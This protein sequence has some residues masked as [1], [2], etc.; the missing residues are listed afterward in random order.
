MVLAYP[1]KIMF[2]TFVPAI[3]CL[4]GGSESANA[5]SISLPQPQDQALRSPNH[6]YR[7]VI[8]FDFAWRHYNTPVEAEAAEYEASCGPAF[9]PFE[10]KTC[11]TDRPVGVF[12]SSGVCETLCCL[13]S[14]CRGWVFE[15]AT[16][17][18]RLDT[19]RVFSC[20]TVTKA[21]TV[22][23]TRSIPAPNPPLST[24][25]FQRMSQDFDDS[26]WQ[27]VDAPHDSLISSEFSV[28]ASLSQGSLPYGI[29]YYR[30]HF[31]LPSDW[32]GK[33]QTSVYFEGIFRS[34]YV[35]LN[36]VQIAFHESGYTSF[37]VRLDNV[38]GVKFGEGKENE[39]VLAIRAQAFGGSGWWYEGGGLYRHNYLV[40]HADVHIATNGILG[41]LSVEEESIHELEGGLVS[42][43]EKVE[44]AVE[45]SVSYNANTSGDVMIRFQLFDANDTEVGSG[46]TNTTQM[47][48]GDTAIFFSHSITL[49]NITIWTPANT[50]MYRLAVKVDY[51]GKVVDEV[52]D[53]YIGAHSASWNGGYGFVLNGQPFKW[54]GFCNHNDMAGVGIA[55]PDRLHLFRAQ[56]MKSIGG[57]SWRMSHNPPA[58]TLLDVLD[59]TGILVWDET[60][61]FGGEAQWVRDMHDMVQRDRNHPSIMLWSFCNEGGCLS[62]EPDVSSIGG[63]FRGAAKSLDPFRPV[64]GNMVAKT[65]SQLY[66]ELTGEIDV[67][68]FSHMQ[69]FIFDD[70]HSIY[71]NKPLINSECCSCVTQRGE[72]EASPEHNSNF[73]ADCISEQT[74]RGMDRPFVSGSLVWTLFD[75]L[76]EPTPIEWPHVSSSFGS[77]DLAGFNKAASFWYRAW[78]L[79]NFTRDQPHQQWDVPS[80]APLLVDAEQMQSAPSTKDTGDFLVHIV[81]HWEPKTQ[82]VPGD[83]DLRVIQVY[84]N[85]PQVQLFVNGKSVGR[86]FVQSYGWAE[87]KNVTFTAGNLTATAS[88]W[89]SEVVAAHSRLTS[90]AA[91][92]IALVVDV[93]S[94]STGTGKAL[95][96]DGQDTGMIRAMVVDSHGTVVPS[97]SHRITFNV[98]SGPGRIIGVGNGDPACH[99]NN[100]AST[101]SAYHGLARAIVQ[102]SINSAMPQRVRHRLAQIDSESGKYTVLVN[103]GDEEKYTFSDGIVVSAASP[104]LTSATLTIPVT[105]DIEQHNVLATA[106]SWL[107]P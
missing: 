42:L 41:K 33:G 4:Y 58:P 13:S 61:N 52:N 31:N 38:T 76:G 39:N 32:Q 104:G 56:T 71:P 11:K 19:E 47:K 23:G 69:G 96:L 25:D 2:V 74:S 59:R 91:V 95:V 80:R 82:S 17:T 105:N 40:H 83:V 66:S 55:L 29:A 75:Y 53:T 28:N 68:G 26:K 99:E 106:S 7:E 21:A 15:L 101:R 46:H 98:S 64:T 86:Q 67:Q 63:Q 9:T 100:K 102:V 57:N 84:T 54:R 22:G 78:W 35:Y 1:Q 5:D 81:Q 72:D 92:A 87:Y 6:V 62:A 79:Y 85:A 70:F 48:P 8:N 97:S 36:G 45:A 93:P 77:F 44:I 88:S 89:S 73:N 90:G 16:G 14:Y 50:Y 18:C 34:S 20:D 107:N 12:A 27:L 65:E 3:L 49:Q 10:N 30:K 37:S 51:A 43:A 24:Q 60:R 103:P 94:A